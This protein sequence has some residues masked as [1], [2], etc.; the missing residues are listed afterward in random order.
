MKRKISIL[1]ST[2]S[3]GKQA[4]EVV[5]SLPDSFEIYA[6]AAGANLTI[7]KEQIKK[8]NPEVVSVK[9]EAA[10]EELQKE[11]QDIKVLCGDSGLI[12]I[13][14]NAENNL[15][16]VAVTGIAGL[17]PTLAAINNKID[18]ALANKETLVAAGSIVM[19]RAS[20]NN[21]KIFPVDSEH[22]AI[23]R[24]HRRKNFQSGF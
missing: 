14:Q 5:D 4:L 16:L 13:S 21:V 24:V 18:V 8:Y 19:D 3:I 20:K 10:A 1:G 2:G 23:Y 11:F 15:V 6:L 12:E 9:S 22:S 17:F 7:F